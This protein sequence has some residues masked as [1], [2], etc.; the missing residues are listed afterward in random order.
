MI[1][2]IVNIVSKYHAMFM[3]GILMTI[4]LCLISWM[5]GIFFGSATGYWAS[6][7]EMVR[8]AI[9]I[10]SFVV[11][12]VPVIVFLFLLHYPLQT[13]LG[14]T[15]DPF[16]TATLMLS[17]LN[18]LGVSQIVSN[19]I[20]NLPKQYLEVAKV[21]GLSHAAIFKKIELPLILRQIIPSLLTAQVNILHLSLFASLISVNEL[22]KVSQ[23]VVSIEYRPVEIYTLLGVFFLLI[24]LPINGLALYLRRKYNRSLDE[25]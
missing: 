18:M 5:V 3:S 23:R 2:T 9:F 19:A 8:K 13:L 10:T 6:K 4:K 21:C 12:G 1:A 24:S 14:I 7:Q 25:K 22:F 17:V 15:V 20:L 11:S 16:L